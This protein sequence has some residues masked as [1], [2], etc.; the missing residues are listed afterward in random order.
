M[1]LSDSEHSDLS[2]HF[3]IF[4]FKP[5]AFRFHLQCRL[6]QWPVYRLKLQPSIQ[7]TLL[8]L[9]PTIQLLH[10]CKQL[11]HSITICNTLT[12][13]FTT[14]PKRS[15]TLEFNILT[16]EHP[17][18]FAFQ[19]FIVHSNPGTP[20]RNIS[21]SRYFKHQHMSIQALLVLLEF[22]LY[23]YNL[24]QY[25]STTAFPVHFDSS[26]TSTFQF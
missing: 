23:Q 19:H 9:Q 24:H 20:H 5:N 25:N 2:H 17:A 22:Q 11:L 15:S 18:E 3:I 1:V 16:A 26:T 8:R 10:S 12:F 4:H 21:I 6:F 7:L 13:S 14:S